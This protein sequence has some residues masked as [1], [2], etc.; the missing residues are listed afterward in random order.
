MSQPI[1][2]Q[3]YQ[4][5]N[6][7]KTFFL[8][9]FTKEL[10]KH[11]GASEV[12]E[13]E[14]TLNKEFNSRQPLDTKEEIKEKVKKTIKKRE[15]HSDTQKKNMQNKQSIFT[16]FETKRA[17]PFKSS[18]R[19]RIFIPE[20]NLPLRFQY[21]KPV[22]TNVQIDLEKL[23][24]LIKDPLVRTIRC[25]G[26]DENIVVEGSMGIKPTN[27]ILTKQE[28]EQLIKKFSETA[29]IP[30]YEGIFRVAVGK[31]ILL[32]IISEVIGTKF[33]IKKIIYPFNHIPRH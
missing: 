6:E 33:I 22:P 28:I 17:I 24:P 3:F 29:K 5:P 13:L 27:I 1:G 31:L 9:Q 26:P 25:D 10:I 30:I 2:E 15:K 16:S 7:I 4:T 14:K 18:S 32:A 21:L 12:F 19:R 20:P 11:A 8:L 23:N